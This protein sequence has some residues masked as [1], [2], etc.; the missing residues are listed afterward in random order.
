MAGSGAQRGFAAVPLGGCPLLPVTADLRHSFRAELP[1]VTSADLRADGGLTSQ[2]AC[3]KDSSCDAHA[4]HSRRWSGPR[5]AARAC[6]RNL[7]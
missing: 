4:T 2:T 6:V 1:K 7:P 3:S 5:V